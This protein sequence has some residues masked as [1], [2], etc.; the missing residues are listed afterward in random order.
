MRAA[1]CVCV[2]RW[3]YDMVRGVCHDPVVPKDKIKTLNS[4]K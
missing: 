1:V 4:C 3:V 2:H